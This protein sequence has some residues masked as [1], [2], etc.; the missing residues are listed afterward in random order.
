MGRQLARISGWQQLK[1]PTDW[2]EKDEREEEKW[3]PVAKQMQAM[4]VKF[5][6][7]LT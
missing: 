1:T 7:L 2:K 5:V 3:K 6:E 4:S